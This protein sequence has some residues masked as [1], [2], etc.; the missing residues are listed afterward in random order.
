MP[1]CNVDNRTIFCKD[2]LDVLQG[3]N[4]NWVKIG[5]YKSDARY[6][7]N[8]KGKLMQDVWRLPTINNKAKERVRYPTQKPL[9]LLERIIKASSKENDIILDPF[10]GCATTCVASE[11]LGR[12]WIGV[13]ISH[14]AYPRKIYKSI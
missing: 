10:Y 13:D 3:I 4:S 5:G 9:A 7:P 12:K 11:K 1:K 2:N 6:S 8:K 14:K